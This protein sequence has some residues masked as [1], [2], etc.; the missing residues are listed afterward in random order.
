MTFARETPAARQARNEARK[1]ANLS[2][3]RPLDR[4]VRAERC[5]AG[6]T[7]LPKGEKAKPGKR[8]PTKD[9]RE[10]MDAIT[11]YGCIACRMDGLG[12]VPPAVHHILRG[13]VRMGHLFTLPL[14]PAH[15]QHDSS[16]GLIA[17]HPH[18]M[19]FERKYGS[20]D[21]LLGKLRAELGVLN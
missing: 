15:H 10:W 20:E 6:A 8:T 7:P 5:E 4:P 9:E 13:G 21:S 3:L 16:S 12:V 14:C 18:K 19:Q 17:R 11:S 1:A 2:A